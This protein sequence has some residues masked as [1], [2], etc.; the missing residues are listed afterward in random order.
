MLNMAHRTRRAG[1]ILNVLLVGL[2][3]AVLAGPLRAQ[4]ILLADFEETNYVW[5]PGGSWTV[6]GTAMGPGPAQGTLAGQQLVS[7]Y[8][9]QGLVNTF[10]N[11]DASTGT[12]TSPPF[13]LTRNYLKFL[14]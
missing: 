8:L 2:A 14:I 6:T 3:L 7:G 12:L 9:G 1:A 4:D 5:L 11:G 10:Y 13:P